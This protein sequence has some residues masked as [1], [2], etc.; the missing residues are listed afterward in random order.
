MR[1]ST[2]SGEGLQVLGTKMVQVKYE[3]Q[4][5]TLPLIVVE[6]TG[7]LLL[8]RNW[9]SHQLGSH[10]EIGN[11]TGSTT[12]QVPRV[13]PRRAGHIERAG[14]WKR[15]PSQSFRAT[16]GTADILPSPLSTLRLEGSY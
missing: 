7:V 6:G 16:W 2:Y 9:H 1:L 3:D 5:N 15:C 13:V 10:K 11:P 8:G 4:V 14:H 12:G